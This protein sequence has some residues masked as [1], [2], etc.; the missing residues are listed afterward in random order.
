MVYYFHDW[1]GRYKWDNYVVEEDPDHENK[2]EA[3]L[4]TYEYKYDYRRLIVSVAN[5]SSGDST[6]TGSVSEDLIL[7]R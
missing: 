6:E 2:P 1:G 4:A 7:Q 5:T 3:R